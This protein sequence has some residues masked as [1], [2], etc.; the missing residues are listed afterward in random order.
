MGNLLEVKNLHTYYG[1]AH[2]LQGVT[3]SLE[4]SEAVALMGRNGEGKTT[5]FKSIMFLV[6]PKDGDI[7]YDGESIPAL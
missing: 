7:L 4:E 3:L 2:I 5:T 1:L 6:P